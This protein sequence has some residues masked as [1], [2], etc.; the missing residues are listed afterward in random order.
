[1]PKKTYLILKG[2]PDWWTNW[3]L[4]SIVLC[5]FAILL[6]ANTLTHHYTQDDAIVLYDNMFTTSGLEGISGILKYDTFYG[7]FKEEGKAQLVAGG[8]YRPLSLVLF[9]VGWELFGDNPLLFHLMNV[10]WY[11]LTGLMLYWLLLRLLNRQRNRTNTYFL[12]LG[13]ALLFVVHPIHTEAVANIKGRDEILTLLGS[14]AALYCSIRAYD[15]KKIKWFILAGLLFFLGL[16]A[17]ENAITFLAIIP[18]SLWVFRKAS[19]G[20]IALFTVP[21]IIGTTLFLIIRF[22]ILGWNISESSM[23]LMNNPFLKIEKNQWV[24]FSFA[25]WSATIVF[26]LGNYIQLLFF[27]HPL[28]HDYYPRHVAIMQWS[29]WQ[30]LLSSVVHLALLVYALW[31]LPKRDLVSYGILFYFITLSIVSNVVF[32]IGTNM[33]ERFLFM[34]SVGFCL[35]IAVLLWRLSSRRKKLIQFKQLYSALAILGIVIVLFSVKTISR[36]TAWKDN[37]TLFTTDI[38]T[39]PNSAKLRNGVA[40]VLLDRALKETNT[41]KQQSMFQEAKGHATKAIEIHPTYKNAYLLLG[42]A[43][44]YLKQYEAAVQAYEQALRIDANYEDA[45]QNLALTYRDA[46]KYYGQEKGEVQK[47]IQYLKK[48]NTLLPNDAEILRLLGIAYGIS[49]QPQQAVETLEKAAAIAPNNASILY[50]LGAAYSSL[51]ALEKAAS[52]I[53]R[54]KEI[55]PTIGQN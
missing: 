45:Q 11:A 38:Y 24:A 8:R 21:T 47:A 48:A 29:D 25:E 39:S 31:K 18:L 30:V 52:Y 3:K 14:L 49:Q 10:L 33:G 46:G 27:P 53:A 35:V 2:Q 17:K 40:G 19:I 51:G 4:Q 1:M 42:N 43:N 55:D 34:P 7:F 15:D 50:N 6:Y 16:M 32:P 37:F 36:N 12:A 13:A 5:L 41:L 28:T 20:E 9:A 22:S 44:N 26:T 54:A 23:E